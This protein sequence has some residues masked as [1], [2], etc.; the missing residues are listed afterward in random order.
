MLFEPPLTQLVDMALFVFRVYGRASSDEATYPGDAAEHCKYKPCEFC[1]SSAMQEV[2]QFLLRPARFWLCV[3]KL[4]WHSAI[5]W[6]FV[7]LVGL[8]RFSR[9]KLNY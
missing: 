7:A 2:S 6:F 1:I 8:L 3:S 9:V 4:V 5:C